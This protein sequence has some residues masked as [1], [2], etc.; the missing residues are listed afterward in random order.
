MRGMLAAEART[1]EKKAQASALLGIPYAPPQ[2]VKAVPAIRTAAGLTPLAELARNLVA[3][4]GVQPPPG[5]TP[6]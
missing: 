1:Q 5:S 2:Q 4:K 3:S 6:P